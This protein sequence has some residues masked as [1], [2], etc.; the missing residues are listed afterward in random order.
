MKAVSNKIDRK[1]IL[2]IFYSL[3]NSQK[4]LELLLL[5]PRDFAVHILRVINRKG[6]LDSPSN[7][8]TGQ[9]FQMIVI[10]INYYKN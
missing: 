4:C 5:F 10:F 2:A 7:E 1:V 8:F 9:K 3:P 6:I